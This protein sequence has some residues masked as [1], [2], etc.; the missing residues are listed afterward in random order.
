MTTREEQTHTLRSW[1]AAG[2]YTLVMSSSFFGTPFHAGVLS[3]LISAGLAPQEVAGSSSGGLVAALYA[4]G[5]GMSELL[6]VMKRMA[7]TGV[8]QVARPWREPGGVFSTDHVQ[9]LLREVIKEHGLCSRL[10]DCSIPVSITTFDVQGLQSRTHRQGD[11]AAVCAASCAVPAFFSPVRL[12]GRPQLDGGVA[13][14]PGIRGI[15]SEKRVLYHHATIWPL[16]LTTLGSYQSS[17]TL[18]IGGLPLMNPFNLGRAAEAFSLAKEATIQALDRALD[19][20]G[21]GAEAG[22]GGQLG[23]AQRLHV[24]ARL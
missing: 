22:T 16:A 3:A 4:G 9:V 14:M 8:L 10:E 24:R 11:L 20:R 1:L 19:C 12:D 21:G 7:E 5:L 6:E 2:P 18:Q 15:G 13:D 23:G 17:V